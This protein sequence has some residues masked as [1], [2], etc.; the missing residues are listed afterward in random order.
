MNFEDKI[1]N[2]LRQIGGCC[3]ALQ[4]TFWA[5][6]QGLLDC[7]KDELVEALVRRGVLERHGIGRKAQL[8]LRDEAQ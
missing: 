2:R 4:M 1:I 6:R 3:T 5:R 8:M 7:Q